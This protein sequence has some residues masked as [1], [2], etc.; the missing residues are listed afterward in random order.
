MSDNTRIAASVAL[1]ERQDSRLSEEENQSSG[2]GSGAGYSADY[3]SS[4]SSLSSKQKT[5]LQQV[6]EKS[7]RSNNKKD[8]ASMDT[9]VKGKHKKRTKSGEQASGNKSV[10]SLDRTN[11]QLQALLPQWNGIRITHPMDPRIDLSTV[12]YT[13]NSNACAPPHSY[14]MAPHTAPHSSDNSNSIDHYL[15]LMEAVKPF[16]GAYTPVVN[17]LAGRE[18]SSD[19]APNT[20]LLRGIHRLFHDY[21][22]QYWYIK[23]KC[24]K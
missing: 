11:E 4:E 5:E 3:E 18:P 23:Y 16:F 6:E 20:G 2:S 24:F 1:P 13:V 17:P 22:Q 14:M 15:S 7:N 10:S 8:T 21:K 19:Q 12:G 9:G